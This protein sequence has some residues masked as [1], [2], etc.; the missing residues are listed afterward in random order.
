MLTKAVFEHCRVAG[1]LE[2]GGLTLQ[3]HVMFNKV[4]DSYFCG[5][6]T[7]GMLVLRAE[8]LFLAQAHSERKKRY[9]S[10]HLRHRS[11]LVQIAF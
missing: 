6:F 7:P 8:P 5:A 10:Q 3:K 11:G 1:Y 2:L 4:L 9:V